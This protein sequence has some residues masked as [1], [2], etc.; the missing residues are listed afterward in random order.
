[1]DV[2]GVD[3]REAKTSKAAAASYARRSQIGQELLRMAAAD[4]EADAF[5]A[6]RF[7]PD[8]GVLVRAKRKAR[9][10]GAVVRGADGNLAGR[11]VRDTR[12]RTV[13]R[14]GE[15]AVWRTR[16]RAARRTG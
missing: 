10:R 16:P 7:R 9:V 4:G 2:L 12:P 1:M 8:R 3:R 11:W 14:K 5:N 6:F 13:T 15:V